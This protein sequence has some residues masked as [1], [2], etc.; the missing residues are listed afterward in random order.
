MKPKLNGDQRRKIH[1]WAHGLWVDD[2]K[3]LAKAKKFVYLSLDDMVA[4]RTALLAESRQWKRRKL[5]VDKC[6][7]T[8]LP[9]C[10][11]QTKDASSVICA[12]H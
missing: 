9:L 6:M 4:I 7:N 1:E 2:D 5:N 10:D 3:A 11:K 8:L 12:C